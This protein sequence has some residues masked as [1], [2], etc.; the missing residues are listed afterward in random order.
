M[1]HTR[2]A[3]R[4]LHRGRSP[5]EVEGDSKLTREQRTL[6]KGAKSEAHSSILEDRVQWD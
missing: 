3:P 1:P 2:Q 6:S 5:K 4:T